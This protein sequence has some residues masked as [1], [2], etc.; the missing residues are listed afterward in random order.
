MSERW[1]VVLNDDEGPGFR[2]YASGAANEARPWTKLKAKAW[3]FPSSAD[4]FAWVEAR[5][6]HVGGFGTYTVRRPRPAFRPG[7]GS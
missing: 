5:K 4:A 2:E 7:G 3:V 1:L 6:I